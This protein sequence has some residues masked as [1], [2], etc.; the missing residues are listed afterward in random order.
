[1]TDAPVSPAAQ[2]DELDAV[3]IFY[4]L[5]PM[6]ND[7]DKQSTEAMHALRIVSKYLPEKTVKFMWRCLKRSPPSKV[8]GRRS[9]RPV[10][11]V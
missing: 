11:S 10:N 7:G 8:S 1:M 6:L 4:L 2:E 5:Y 3:A 9:A